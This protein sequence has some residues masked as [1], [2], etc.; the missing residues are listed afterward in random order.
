VNNDPHR[1]SSP[2]PPSRNPQR[3]RTK[4]RMR[5]LGRLGNN[6]VKKG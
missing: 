5:Y 3:P 6:N 2:Q 1:A 4:D